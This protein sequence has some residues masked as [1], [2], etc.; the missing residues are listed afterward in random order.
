MKRET[1]NVP[2]EDPGKGGWWGN[3]SQR[4]QS[5][6]DVENPFKFSAGFHLFGFSVHVKISPFK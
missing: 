4:I 2:T 3:M 6:R 5:L 1:P